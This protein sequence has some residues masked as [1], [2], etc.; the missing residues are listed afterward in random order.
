MIALIAGVNVLILQKQRL[1]TV[2]AVSTYLVW[3][4]YDGLKEFYTVIRITHILL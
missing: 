3:A 1:E 2:A 4:A